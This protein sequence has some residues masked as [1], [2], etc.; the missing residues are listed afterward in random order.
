MFLKEGH[1]VVYNFIR[2]H[3]EDVADDRELREWDVRVD[4]WEPSYRSVYEDVS[5]SSED[6]NGSDEENIGSEEDNDTNESDLISYEGGLATWMGWV[7]DSSRSTTMD[8]DWLLTM[9]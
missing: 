4:E 1:M 6:D 5:S 2:A 3:F 8:W 9:E 7:D